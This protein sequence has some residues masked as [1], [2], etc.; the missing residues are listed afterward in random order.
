MNHYQGGGYYY[1]P[2]ERRKMSDN[3][4]AQVTALSPRVLENLR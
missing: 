3:Q 2:E 4:T 1:Q